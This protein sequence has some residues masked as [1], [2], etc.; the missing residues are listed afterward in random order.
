M[1][2]QKTDKLSPGKLAGYG[3]GDL[4]GGGSFILIGSFYMFF[5]TQ[6]IGLS[7][8]VAGFIFAIGKVWDAI[9]DPLMG[10]ISDRTRSRY[11]RRRIFFLLAPFPIFVSFVMM[12]L[13]LRG[14]G[15]LLTVLYYVGTYLFFNTVFTMVMVPYTAINAEITPSYEERTKL[16][17]ARM[18]F[19]QIS[20]LLS[21]T[22]PMMIINNYDRGYQIMALIFGALYASPWLIV[23]FSTRENCPVESKSPAS[24]KLIFQ[25]FLSI[26]KNRS[27]RQLAG[28]YI[29]SYTAMDIMM[30]L[31][32]FILSYYLKM[33]AYY[34]AAMGSLVITQLILLPVYVHLANKRGKGVAYRRGLTIWFLAL[35][36]VVLLSES[37]PV[38]M[39]ITICIALGSGEIAG[40]FVPWAVLPSVVDVD[41]MITSKKRSGTYSG[42][43]TMIRKMVQGLVA[44]PLVGLLLEIVGFREGGVI[45]ENLL[46]L[47]VVFITMPSLF[48]LSGILISRKFHITP[49][50]HKILSDEISRLREGGDKDKAPR[51]VRDVC[52]DLCGQPWDSLYGESSSGASQV[53]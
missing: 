9:S 16:S 14:N 13:P 18:I 49:D 37:S 43:M 40:V 31:F 50:S 7:P 29:C 19:S 21:A 36:A 53:R 11:G 33:K 30:A 52:E 6:V 24:T 28:M 26:F 17:G 2:R 42:A 8:T 46:P 48:I 35:I 47:K 38:W 23:F 34:S 1:I 27:F 10:A 25:Q 39:L 41:E 44:M 32:V 45:P 3:I 5:L 51:E 4:Y 20:A 15:N 22:V 12:W